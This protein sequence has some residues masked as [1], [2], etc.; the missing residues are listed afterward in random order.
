LTNTCA[1]SALPLAASSSADVADVEHRLGGQQLACANTRSSSSP[2][3]SVSRAGLPARSSFERLAEHA[4]H[5]LGFLVAAGRAPPRVLD[6]LLE[7]FEIGQHQL[8]LDHLGIGDRVDLVGDM[9]DVRRPSKQRST[10]T[11][12]STSR[13]LPR[14]WLPRPSPLLAPLHQPGDVDERQLRRDDL[15]RLG[16]R[17]ELVE[18]R[19]G[20]ATW[21]TLGSIVQNG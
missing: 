18:P 12:A 16:D 5:R 15:G 7:A 4:R 19:S 6:A 8:G 9:L 10:W 20:T 14:N 17:R 13:M 3:G 11:I 1:L 21:P 2:L